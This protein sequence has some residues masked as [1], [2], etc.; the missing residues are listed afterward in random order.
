MRIDSHQHFWNYNSEKH[1]WI[2]KE[3]AV[4]KRDFLPEDLEPILEK[5][6][7]DG[8][9]AVQ[10]E[11]SEADTDF[12]LELASRFD[13]IKGVVGWLD[14]RADDLEE[15][16]EHYCSFPV[17]KGIRH[18]V[19]D[20]RG[21]FLLNPLF[22]RGLRK[23]QKY[24]LSFDLLV[25]PYQLRSAVELAQKLPQQQFVLNHLAKP[26]ISKG[27]NVEWINGIRQLAEC[28]NVYAKLSGMVTETDRFQWK[29]EDFQPFLEAMVEAFG[30]DRLMFGSDWPVSTCAAAYEETLG[31]VE[32]FFKAFSG[33]EKEAVFGG[34]AARFYRLSGT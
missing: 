5:N 11:A 25:F 6:N 29:Q 24:G 33:T 30:T 7:I 10:V 22:Q 1:S 16:L 21:E 4:I 18:T 17:L 13:F 31:I 3:M 34:N 2:G 26:N 19:Y 14:L 23:F 12:L 20:T 8:S 15:K 27:V 32:K 9:I 28:K